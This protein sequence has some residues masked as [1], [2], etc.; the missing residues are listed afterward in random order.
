MEHQYRVHEQIP[1]RDGEDAL[2]EQLL[3]NRGITSEE[4][5]AFLAPNYETH[6]HDPFLITDMQVAV[7]R[8]LQALDTDEKVVIYSDYDCD[9]IPAGTLMHDLFK[10]VGMKDF[11]NYIPHRHFEGFGLNADAV[12]KFIAEG[13][14]LVITLDCGTVS[15]DEIALARANGIDVIVIDHH[16]PEVGRLPETVALL[17]PKRDMAY[18]FRELCASGVSFKFAQALLQTLRARGDTDIPAGWEKWLLDVVALATISDMV[19]L[20]DENRVF[21]YYGLMVLRKSRR[22]GLQK[23]LRANKLNPA[24]LTEDDIGFTIA[25]RINAASRMDTPQIG[26]MMLSGDEAEGAAAA[27]K[28]ERLNKE[29]RGVVAAMTKEVQVRL[30]HVEEVPPVLVMGNP[31]W[32]PSLVGLVANS[33]MET[34]KRPVFIWGRDGK[35]IIKGSCRSA[36]V[37]VVKLMEHARDAFLHHGGHHGA[38]GFEVADDAIHTVGQRLCEAYAVVSAESGDAQPEKLVDAQLSHEVLNESLF[39]TLRSLA[40]YGMQNPKPLFRITGVVP[41][42]VAIFGKIPE[43][44]KLTF[45]T[46]KG[47]MQA[48]AFFK[49]PEAFHVEPKVGTPCT[50]IAHAEESFFMGRKERRL[51]IVDILV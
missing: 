29:R 12:R 40:P 31:E 10:K 33:L 23:L 15:F 43:H 25:P 34:Y 39:K 49:K 24:M 27:E 11:S 26:F 44:T 37:S 1:V 13:V 32:K 48:I 38:G 18:P 17:N 42:A 2:L 47:S 30:E 8:V 7:D 9:G 16:E 46:G 4:R 36:G 22:P 51:R 19:S 21:V 41:D 35:G 45:T 6:L 20:R 5:E 50:L 28:L 14:Q 3:H